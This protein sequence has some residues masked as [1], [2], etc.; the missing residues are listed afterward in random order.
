MLNNKLARHFITTVKPPSRPVKSMAQLA[1]KY[2]AKGRK[3]FKPYKV[4]IKGDWG[5]QKK[6]LTTEGR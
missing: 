3:K 4:K 6:K 1:D 2:S 5:W